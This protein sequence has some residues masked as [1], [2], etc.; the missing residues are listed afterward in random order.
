MSGSPT[1]EIEVP[2]ALA[3]A[4]SWLRYVRRSSPPGATLTVSR[5]IVEL[6]GSTK[7][8][9]GASK[10]DAKRALLEY[11]LAIANVETDVSDM[12]RDILAGRAGI[13]GEVERIDAAVPSERQAE[14][15]LQAVSAARQ[16]LRDFLSLVLTNR[17]VAAKRVDPAALD[18]VWALPEMHGS[19]LRQHWVVLDATAFE[20]IVC[21]LL[22]SKEFGR[23]LKQCGSAD[24]KKFFFRERT[25]GRSRDTYCSAACYDTGHNERRAARRASRR[26]GK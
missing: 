11:A 18:H 9:K 8:R 3:D 1:V 20:A 17:R 7:E 10:V 14:M 2:A 6:Y 25:R 5:R 16:R 12:Q 15:H 13:A 19:A 21:V 22:V 26:K 24:C 4:R 23:D